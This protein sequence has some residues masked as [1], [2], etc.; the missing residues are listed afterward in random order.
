MS[1]CRTLYRARA[2]ETS[3]VGDNAEFI[4]TPIAVGRDEF[5]AVFA[6]LSPFR[7]HLSVLLPEPVHS[8]AV[9]W[10]ALLEHADVLQKILLPSAFYAG[11]G[12]HYVVR[13]ARTQ[14][15]FLLSR[16]GRGKSIE[17]SFENTLKFRI[18]HRRVLLQCGRI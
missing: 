13:Y 18:G 10:K 12:V 16:R 4:E 2:P 1:L 6:H 5:S 8:E 15:P 17:I 3:Q 7:K 11:V 14:Q 9:S